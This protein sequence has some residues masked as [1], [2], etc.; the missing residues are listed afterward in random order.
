[1]PIIARICNHHVTSTQS[2]KYNYPTNVTLDDQSDCAK[3]ASSMKQLFS[4]WEDTFNVLLN[5]EH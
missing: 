3:D 4:E 1:M 2:I 5:Y